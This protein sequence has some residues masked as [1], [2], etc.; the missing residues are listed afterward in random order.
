MKKIKNL[1]LFSVLLIFSNCESQTSKMGD[2]KLLPEPQEFSITGV[3]D[4]KYSD[5]KFYYALNNKALPENGPLLENILEAKIRRVHKF[6][7]Q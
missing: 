1:L 5:L 4:L 7:F 2:F 6:A 3:S